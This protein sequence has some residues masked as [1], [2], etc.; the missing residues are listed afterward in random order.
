MH[1]YQ[2]VNNQWVEI[3]NND[4]APTGNTYAPLLGGIILPQTGKYLIAV[5]RY[6]MER[7]N[8]AGTFSITLTLN[9]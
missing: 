6:G 4:D 7:E 1:L 9:S 2:S 5:N 3:A 8:T